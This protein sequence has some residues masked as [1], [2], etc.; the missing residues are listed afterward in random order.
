MPVVYTIMARVTDWQALR[1]LHGETLIGRAREV[2]ALGYRVYRNVHDASQMLV[3]A[4]L[5]DHE[6]VRELEPHLA[7][8][9]GALRAGGGVDDRVWEA[10]DVAGIGS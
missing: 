9:L 4:E 6:A 2:G 3:V 5:P 7:A 8:A 10:A 1:R